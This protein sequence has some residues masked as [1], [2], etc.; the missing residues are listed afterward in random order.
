[1]S[2]A[3]APRGAAAGRG[4]ASPRRAKTAV[5]QR[6]QREAARRAILEAARELLEQHAW[7]E[8]PLDEVMGRAGLSRTVFYRHFDDRQRLLLALLDEIGEDLAAT[9]LA[10]KEGSGDRVDEAVRGLRELTATYVDHGRLLQALADAAGQDAEV[11]AVYEQLADR[12]VDVVEQRLAGEVAAGRSAVRDPR[13]V[14]RALVWMNERY[15]LASFGR[16]PL[17]DPEPVAAALAEVWLATVYGAAPP[18]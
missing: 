10:W 15:L 8:L 13:E 14:A 9:G 18:G 12:L 4:A 17:A 1:V 3:A 11:R 5:R 7:H 6:T 16:P 2:D